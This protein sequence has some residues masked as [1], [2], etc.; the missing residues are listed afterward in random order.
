[1]APAESRAVV[2]GSIDVPQLVETNVSAIPFHHRLID[3]LVNR[4]TVTSNA[5]TYVR[6]T[7]R[8]NNAAP[9]ADNA[10]KPTSTFTVTSVEDRLRVIA[11]LSEAIPLRFFEDDVTNFENWLN[12]EMS[13]GVLNALEAQ[14][15]SGSGSGENFTGILETSGTTAVAFNTDMVTTLRK[16]RTAMQLINERPNAIVLNPADAEVLDLTRV[17]TGGAF[18]IDG[19]EDDSRSS[20]S[21]NVFGSTIER[22]VSNSV[23]AGTAILGD[24]SQVRLYIRS[25]IRIDVDA[26]GALFTNNQ[27]K[28]RAEG[29]YGIGVLRPQAFAIIETVDPTP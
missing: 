24:W 2:S 26:G 19:Y 25:T 8:T 12:K 1:M 9:V 14:V 10:L 11:H 21:D 15:V 3:L 13:E 22:V 23:P 28:L 7:V 5:F 16:A 6:Q 4:Q 27:A 18:L 17:S 29:R 20:T